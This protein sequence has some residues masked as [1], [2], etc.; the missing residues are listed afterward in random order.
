MTIRAILLKIVRQD[1]VNFLLTNRLPRRSATRLMGWFSRIEHPLVYAVSLRVWRLFSEVDLSDAAQTEFRSLH[2]CFTRRLKDGAR[3]IDAD[4]DILVSPCDG[5]I[6]ASG[7]VE[8][9][10]VLQ[11][12]GSPYSLADL[13]GDAAHAGTFDNGRYVTIRL[14]S[15]MY[16]HFHAA[17]DCRIESVTHIFGDAWNVNPV[18][19]RRVP[20]LFCRNER[21]LIR[22]TLPAT[23]HAVTL[24]AVAAILVAGIR[25]RFL[26]ISLGPG[27]N[28][29]R[30]F[31]CGRS[32]RKGEA[33]GWFE[34]GSTMI[35]LAPDGFRL[36]DGIRE[37]VAVRV[38]QPLMRMPRR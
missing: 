19:L 17:H 33:L 3:T 8:G 32:A 12:K 14:T 16:H 30:S 38:G 36:H 5:I 15:G 27:Q 28:S 13:L 2:A 31:P 4:Q 7:V 25:L 24:V 20:R 37:G 10:Q 1:D 6:G 18:T 34:H 35:V 21:A 9:D 11:V 23:G 29:R 22:T 26:D